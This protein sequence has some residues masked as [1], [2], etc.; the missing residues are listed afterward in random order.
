MLKGGDE[1]KTK[2]LAEAEESANKALSIIAQ[3][4]RGP[5]E[6]DEMLAKRK[7]MLGAGAHAALGLVHLQRS[8]MSLEGPDKEELAKA[9]QEYRTAVTTVD[10]PTPEDYYRLGETLTIE[11]KVPE[12]LAAFMKA[13]ELSAGTALKAYADQRLEEIKKK[14]PQAQP[15]AKP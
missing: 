3:I 9:E 7:G 1:G 8:W 13:S 14:N 5:Q 4:P 12:A 10:N 11:N 15:A 6:T 2:R